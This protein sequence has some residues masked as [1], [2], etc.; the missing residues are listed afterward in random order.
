MISWC[1]CW[2]I[3]ITINFTL[4]LFFY[5]IYALIFI[6]Y[7]CWEIGRKLF[8]YTQIILLF[9]FCF[10]LWSVFLAVHSFLS[11]SSETPSKLNLI[12]HFDVTAIFV[13]ILSKDCVIH[14]LKQLFFNIVWWLYSYLNHHREQSY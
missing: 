9:L 10:S 2:L 7:N 8:I 1:L 13:T 11:F 6:Y 12:L 3:L 14:G 5:F 4:Y